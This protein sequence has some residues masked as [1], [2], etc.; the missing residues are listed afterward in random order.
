M[1]AQD[2]LMRKFLQTP[3]V[4]STE[5]SINTVRYTTKLHTTGLLRL[6]SAEMGKRVG[7]HIEGHNRAG[8]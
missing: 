8:T 4:C 6:L 1:E 3:L 7:T 2:Q 5:G